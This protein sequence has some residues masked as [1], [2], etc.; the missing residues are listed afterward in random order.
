MGLRGRLRGGEEGRPQD[1]GGY[2]EASTRPFATIAEATRTWQG[3]D[4]TRMEQ[5]FREGHHS[6]SSHGLWD[7]RVIGA[8][9]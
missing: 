8:G 5:L 3:A 4:T 1:A 9:C 7:L 2:A 6:Q